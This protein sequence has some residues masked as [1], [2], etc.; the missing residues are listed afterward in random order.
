M[1]VFNSNV[2]TLKTIKNKTKSLKTRKGKNEIK[3]DINFTYYFLNKINVD[4]IRFHFIDS[5]SVV[6]TIYYSFLTLIFNSI[7]EKYGYG[8]SLIYEWDE[9]HKMEFHKENNPYESHIHTIIKKEDIENILTDFFKVNKLD[10]KDLNNIMNFLKNGRKISNIEFRGSTSTK[11]LE[12]F[13]SILKFEKYLYSIFYEEVYIMVYF[14]ISL[15]LLRYKKFNF[16]LDNN[17]YN[18]LKKL[19]ELKSKNSEDMI[20]E[21]FDIND[22][23]K[24]NKK[25]ENWEFKLIYKLCSIKT[26]NSIYNEYLSIYLLAYL[27]YYSLEYNKKISLKKYLENRL[28]L[29]LAWSLFQA[30]KVLRTSQNTKEDKIAIKYLNRAYI[31]FDGNF[32]KNKMINFNNKKFIKALRLVLDKTK[33][34]ITPINESTK[35]MT[36]KRISLFK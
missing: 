12:N 23:I 32:G 26:D 35:I 15:H 25:S 27:K 2:K 18:D 21:M 8:N 36:T 33:L 11:D 4:A 24:I 30:S 14:R 1:D 13:K 17:L 34:I 7:L 3:T 5:N 28:N 20:Y 29:E 9:N 10:E 31:L 16:I 19:P 6:L 22:K